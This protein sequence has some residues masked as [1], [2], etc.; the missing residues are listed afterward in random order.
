MAQYFLGINN[1]RIGPLPIDQLI[2]N[3]LTPDTLVWCSGMSGWAPAREVAEL[4]HLFAPQ[5]PQ[6]QQPQYQQPQYQ[7]PQY[8]QPQYQQPQYQQPQYAF[9]QQPMGVAVDANKVDM[10]LMTNNSKF[11]SEKLG[12]IR[13][14][15]LQMDEQRFNNVS[16]L[17]FKDPVTA[18]ILSL[19]LGSLGVDRFYIGDTGLGVGKLLT[20][21]GCGVWAIIDWFLIMGATR[22]K[23]FQQ[24]SAY[25]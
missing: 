7:Q 10:F 13:E 8:Q 17:Q 20:A 1:Q 4:A 3:G 24:L 25:L 22:E 21:G 11:P 23:N 15:L 16:Y 19:L 2:A 9:G 14:R 18:L 6:Y 5:T 12:M